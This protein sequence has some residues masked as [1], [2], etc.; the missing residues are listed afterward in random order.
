M[1]IQVSILLGETFPKLKNLTGGWMLKKAL[2]IIITYSNSVFYS[3]AGDLYIVQSPHYVV[4]EG[5]D[6]LSSLS[7]M[8]AT[9]ELS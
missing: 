3:F 5:G 6:L 2:G 4:M 1:F 8:R 7:A 9:Q